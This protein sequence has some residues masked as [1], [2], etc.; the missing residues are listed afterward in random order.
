MRF[1]FEIIPEQPI[2]ELLDAIALADE[3]G[4][5]G[6]YS[7]DEIYH[8]DMWSIFAAAAGRTE[9][10]V[11]APGVTHVILR[12][13]TLVAQQALTLDELT[14]GRTEI[15]FSVGNIA[16]L[17]QYGIEWRPRMLA[18]LREAH[19]VLRQFLDAGEIDFQG[20]FYSYSGVFTAARSAQE[21]IRVL[22]GGMGG[23]KS[24]ELAGEISDGLHTACAY[25]PEAVGYAVEHARA[26]AQRGGRD[27]SEIEVGDYVL[28]AIGPNGDAART[29]ARTIAAFY[30]PSMPPALLERHGIEPSTVAPVID[31]FGRGD[32][33]EA[34]R[35]TPDE[36][37]DRISISGTPDEWVETLL[38][39]FVPAGLDHIIVVP[40]DP[41]LVRS[42]AG[43]EVPDL[44]D[45]AGQLRLLDAE[46]A[47]ALG[48]RR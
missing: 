1:S 4:F 10:I 23:P 24:F 11:L 18:R 32:V 20:D 46:V 25:S 22:L 41:F 31:A 48:A 28:G 33:A 19:H 29:A 15:A 36:V 8:K 44:P 45:L 16:M 27:E 6:C 30:I 43:V 5:H 7:A 21:R 14:G 2:E 12:D 17:E 40:A 9:R 47:P 3:L 38:R 37:A 34:L 13:P 35:L 26:G 42:W 39:D